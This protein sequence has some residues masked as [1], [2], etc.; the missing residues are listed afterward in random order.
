MTRKVHVIVA[1]N[2]DTVYDVRIH[3]TRTGAKASYDDFMRLYA[4]DNYEVKWLRAELR[5]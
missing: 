1:V 5:R 2:N 3:E 4:G